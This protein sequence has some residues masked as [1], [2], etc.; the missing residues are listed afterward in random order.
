MFLF[1]AGEEGRWAGAPE[2]LFEFV[3]GLF[4][5]GEA[6]EG[7]EV[8]AVF[9]LGGGEKSVSFGSIVETWEEGKFRG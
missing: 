8:V 7:V 9:E 2:E 5:E 3:E 1:V 4:E 6:A